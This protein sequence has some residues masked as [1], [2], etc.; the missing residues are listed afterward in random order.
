MTVKR[1]VALDMHGGHGSRRRQRIITAEFILGALVGVGFAVW[2][3][4]RPTQP[5]GALVSCWIL[6]IALNYVPLAILASRLS[7]GDGVADELSDADIPREARRA[8]VYQL[9]ILVPLAIVG[10]AA[11]QGVQRNA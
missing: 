4:S 6:G 7:I 11:A 9:W 2:L 10:M 1:F 5:F 3:L 8:G